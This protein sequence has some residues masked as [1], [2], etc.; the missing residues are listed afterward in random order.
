LIYLYSLTN[1]ILTMIRLENDYAILERTIEP[2][3]Y[4][5]DTYPWVYDT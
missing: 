3:R 5:R 1:Q 2:T 4:E